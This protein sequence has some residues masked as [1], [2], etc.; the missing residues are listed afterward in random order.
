MDDRGFRAMCRV[1][2]MCLMSFSSKSLHRGMMC[3]RWYDQRTT[4]RSSRCV[5]CETTRRRRGIITYDKGAALILLCLRE[6]VYGI[7]DL[8]SGVLINVDRLVLRAAVKD[9]AS[10]GVSKHHREEMIRK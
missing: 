9:S 6:E 7:N 5:G 2:Q 10:E 4:E 3:S 8:D 1:R